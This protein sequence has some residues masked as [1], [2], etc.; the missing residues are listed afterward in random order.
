[1]NDLKVF[2][3]FLDKQI[4]PSIATYKD[5]NGPD[6]PNAVVGLFVWA[7]HVMAKSGAS[8]DRIIEKVEHHYDRALNSDNDDTLH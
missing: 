6:A 3:T 4:K 2:Q 1:M 5:E 7:V 8:L